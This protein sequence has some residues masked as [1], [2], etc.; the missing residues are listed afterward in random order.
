MTC[1]DL[2][3]RQDFRWLVIHLRHREIESGIS[4]FSADRIP[5]DVISERDIL[6]S[7]LDKLEEEGHVQLFKTAM[8]TGRPECEGI[9]LKSSFRLLA[10]QAEEREQKEM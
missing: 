2:I 5:H 3:E 10:K 8:R 6:E 1:D 9:T 4:T 7:Y